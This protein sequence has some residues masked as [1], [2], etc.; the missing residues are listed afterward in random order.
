MVSKAPAE[1]PDVL[2]AVRFRASRDR[3][4]DGRSTV[5][6]TGVRVA[7]RSIRRCVAYRKEIGEVVERRDVFEAL[8]GA[9]L[10]RQQDRLA[11]DSRI[12]LQRLGFD[13]PALHQQIAG[14]AHDILGW[15]QI[16]DTPA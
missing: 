5:K 8:N 16:A 11:A 1:L 12:E 4:W 14:A 15:R 2:R 9:G 3:E 10:H 7:E 6:V 13:N